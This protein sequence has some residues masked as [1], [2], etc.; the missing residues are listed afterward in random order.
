MRMER[1]ERRE[2][3]NILTANAVKIFDFI[4]DAELAGVSVRGPLENQYLGAPFG[5]GFPLQCLA[6]HLVI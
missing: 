2:G 6:P 1:L 4:G 3:V 5:P